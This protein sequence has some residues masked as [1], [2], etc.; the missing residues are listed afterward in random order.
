MKHK[1]MH[2]FCTNSDRVVTS[3]TTHLLSFFVSFSL[4]DLS[5]V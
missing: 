1:I 2:K 3:A 5:L 4:L